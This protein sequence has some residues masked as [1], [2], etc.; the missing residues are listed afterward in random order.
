MNPKMDRLYYF[1]FIEEVESW[2]PIG[3]TS[4]ITHILDPRMD[5]TINTEFG[6]YSEICFN[7]M[8]IQNIL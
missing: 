6:D 5:S 7:P 4:F 1:A 8:I 2:F 3:Q